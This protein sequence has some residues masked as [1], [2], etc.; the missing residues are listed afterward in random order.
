[1]RQ[2]EIVRQHDTKDCGV[3]SLLSIIKHYGGNISLEK[4]RIDTH[5]SLEGT[6]AYY[7]IEAA[8]SYGF[9]SYGMKLESIDELN[10]IVLPAILHIEINH[11]QHFV[12]LYKIKRKK[13]EIMDPAKGKINMTLDDLKRIWTKNTIVFYPKYSLPKINPK[14]FF[15]SLA[16]QI[17]KSEKSKICFILLL[18][19]LFT[20]ITIFTSFYFKIGMQL[21]NEENTIRTV[22]LFATPFLLL[23]IIKIMIY[24]LKNYFKTILNKNIDGLIYHSFIHRLFLLP[25]Y[26]IK[27]RT[28]GEIMIRLTELGNFKLF[29]SEMITTIGF[30]SILSIGVGIILYKLNTNLFLILCFFSI[31][32]LLYG[33]ISGKLLYQTVLNVNEKEVQFQ[34]QVVENLDTIITLKNLNV[35]KT[36]IQKLEVKL[37]RF[38]HQNFQFNLLINRVNV[39]SFFLEEILQ[40][41]II[42]IGFLEIQKGNLSLINL[43]TF[44]MLLSYFIGPFKNLIQLIPDYN[45]I[46]VNLDK[47]N[48]FFAIELE[49]EEKGFLDYHPGDITISNLTYYYNKFTP[50]FQNFN[51][52]IKENSCVLFKGKSGCGK[53]TLCQI[54]SRLIET[55]NS[56]IMIGKVNINDYSLQTIYQN[57]TYVGQKETLIQETIKNNICFYR[58]IDEDLFQKVINICHIEEIIVKKPLRYETYLL[59]DSINLSGGEKQRIILAR[60]LLNNFQI[61]IL[62]EALSEVNEELE[63]E[64]IKSIQKA[65]KDK[66]IIYVSHK[67]HDKYFEQVINFAGLE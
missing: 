8:K 67:N 31:L 61:L 17:I 19:I 62:D 47:I 20:G 11:L 59:K 22:I 7:I 54:I 15:K 13:V 1:M 3:C 24:Y 43:V 48:E 6:T 35:L 2:I 46:K 52:H 58:N 57:I 10:N 29:F 37:F 60:A 27:N 55:K 14:N 12:V 4:L 23:Y 65:F 28:T 63:I 51:L 9:D 32:Y 5:T 26:F 33:V 64:I 39:I 40:F 53:S 56:N 50:L 34:G 30:D 18:T 42:T 25:N 21:L 44:E 41:L 38:L 16:V 36:A 49:D 45:C 66:T